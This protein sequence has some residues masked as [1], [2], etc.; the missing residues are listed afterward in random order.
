MTYRVLQPESFRTNVSSPRRFRSERPPRRC[1]P[2]QLLPGRLHSPTA[3][4][5]SI[6]ALHR[7]RHHRSR[8]PTRGTPSAPGSGIRPG[9]RTPTALRASPAPPGPCASAT[10]ASPTCRT[11]SP[12]STTASTA[13]WRVCAARFGDT[14][15]GRAPFSSEA[16]AR[17]T[18]SPKGPP[19]RASSDPRDQPDGSGNLAFNPFTRTFAVQNGTLVVTGDYRTPRRC[20][21]PSA[22]E[23]VRRGRHKLTSVDFR[24]SGAL[25]TA[26]GGN[27]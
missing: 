24:A 12:R 8:R 3:S 22:L 5:T 18:K 25:S 19:A 13:A 10:S 11:A 16:T 23:F 9:R 4:R 15:V 2:T 17:P 21:R 7:R 26:V 1:S 20:S 14:G 27:Q 6:T